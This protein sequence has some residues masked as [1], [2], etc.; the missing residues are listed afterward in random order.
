[1]YLFG[2]WDGSAY[3][4]TVLSYDPAID[5]WEALSPLPEAVGFAAAASLGDRIIVAGGYDGRQES[6]MCSIYHPDGDRWETCAPM[7]QPRGGLGMAVDGNSVYA[8][9]GGWQRASPF[10]ER[11]DGLTNTW[12]SLSSPVQGQ[13]R[14]LGVAS[15]GSVVY[16]VGGWSGD[17]LDTNEAF[18][19]TFRAFLPLGARGE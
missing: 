2:G 1:L 10:N 16:A 18:L 15:L 17:Y 6:A 19:G 8:I 11:Y 9:G 4:D 13:W 12:S 14:N 5:A 3:R 7:I